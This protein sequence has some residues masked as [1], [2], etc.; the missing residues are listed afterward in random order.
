M[1]DDDSLFDLLQDPMLTLLALILFGTLWIVIPGGKS[2]SGITPW[3]LREQIHELDKIIATY[4]NNYWNLMTTKAR[5]E[6]KVPSLIQDE[7]VELLIK[8]Q[9]L[10]TR[11]TDLRT[12]IESRSTDLKNIRS[13]KAKKSKELDKD[14]KMK[15]ELEEEIKLETARVREVSER[16]RELS[17]FLE[18]RTGVPVY[19]EHATKKKNQIAFEAH[20]N[21]LYY[22]SLKNYNKPNWNGEIIRNRRAAGEKIWEIKRKDSIFQKVLDNAYSESQYIYFFVRSDSF[23]IFL[24]A[25]LIAEQKGFLV[26][27]TPSDEGLFV[28]SL[29]EEGSDRVREWH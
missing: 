3:Q 9:D 5:L 28:R 14:R 18:R 10:Q 13:T 27:W 25:R 2:I 17:S 24:H 23:D 15:N 19:S 29:G 20:N 4:E 22:F 8:I 16:K 26:G 11:I 21:Q 6:M 12:A 7:N 1:N